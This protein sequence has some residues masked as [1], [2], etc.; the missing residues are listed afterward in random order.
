MKKLALAGQRFGMLAVIRE[1]KS[2][3]ESRW[4]CLCDCGTE[5]IVR[6]THLTREI[7][8]SC[9]CNRA[10]WCTKHGMTR[11]NIYALWNTMVSRCHN[12]KN[13]S[14]HNYGGR[15]I[16]VCD[17]WRSFA[18]FYADMGERPK[19]HTLDRIDNDG[20]YSPENCKWATYREQANNTRTLRLITFD[21]RTQS[22]SEWERELGLPLKT[23]LHRGWDVAF[24]FTL[25]V[26]DRRSKAVLV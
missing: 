6:G 19:G 18:N 21:G 9:G 13:A 11:S 26:G 23:R 17:R 25:A 22:V 7:I 20:P 14:F 24:A 1:A 2:R 4:L 5:T 12:A 8:S 15:G 3:K 16:V 10:K